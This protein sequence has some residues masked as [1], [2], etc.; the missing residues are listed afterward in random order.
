[1]YYLNPDVENLNRIF[2]QN[3]REPY[4]RLDLNENPGGLP[5]EFVR[6]VLAE[7]TP[8]FIAQYPE[9][10]PFTEKLAEF[11]HTGIENICLVN[12][13]SEG[14]RNI[15]YAFS[16]PG[17]RIVGVIPTYAMFEVYSKMYGRKFEPVRYNED[18]TINVENVLEA[19]TPDTQIAI[20]CNPNNPMGNA[21]SEE[22]MQRIYDRA[23]A[24]EI[25]ILIDEAYFYFYPK[26]FLKFA[27]EHEHVF[28]TRSF[29]KLFSLAGLRLGYVVGWPEGV[30]MVQKLCTPH[31]VNAP[32]MLFARRIMEEPGLIEALVEKHRAGRAWL[33]EELHKNGYKTEGQEGNFLFIQPKTDA[34]TVM[35]RMKAEKGI[36]IK[37]YHGVGALG[38][39]LRVTTA[40][41]QFMERF[42]AGLLEIDR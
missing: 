36:L 11:L 37:T 2:D 25:T 42:L 41:K 27:L 10:L 4:L 13:S 35:N 38:E 26:T 5:E 33:V 28:V 18:L 12:G 21:F 31:N 7:F 40:E 32:A 23:R 16:S 17:G 24:Y 3:M 15:I 8:Q 14:I 6:K 34:T 22:E 30:K 1:M 29:S 19:M 9:T 20:V 39:C